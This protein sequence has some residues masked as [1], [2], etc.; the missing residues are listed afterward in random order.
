MTLNVKNSKTKFFLRSESEAR[1]LRNS[2]FFLLLFETLLKAAR[3]IKV[4]LYLRLASVL[5]F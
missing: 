4:H 2:F 5:T 1:E 3:T